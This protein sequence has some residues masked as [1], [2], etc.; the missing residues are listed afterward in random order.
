M[1]HDE[2]NEHAGFDRTYEQIIN[3][4]Y[5]RELSK[6][7]TDYLKH[8]SKCQV[9]RIR[10]HKSY[11][12]LQSILS[13]FIFF[14]T[15]TIDFVLILSTFHTDMNNVMTITNKFK[16]RVIIVP[17]KNIWIAIIWVKALFDRFNLT[18]W[19]FFKIIISNKNRKFLSDL[20][21]TLF[22][23]LNVKLLYSTVYHSQIDDASKR[24]N[25]IIEI[26]L[27]YHIQIFNDCKDW[28]T[29]VEIMQRTINNDIFSTN[30]SFNEICYEF[31]S[32]NSSNLLKTCNATMKSSSSTKLE[33]I[34]SIAMT[35]ISSKKLYDQ[36]HQSL[37]LKIEDWVLLRFYKDYQILSSIT[38][39]LKLFQQYVNSFEILEKIGNL[40]YRLKISEHWKIWF[41]ISIA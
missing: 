35:Q 6:Q 22:S 23:Q 18:N 27:R 7:L 1:I 2:F 40:A 10:K 34:D 19:D 24:T 29:I 21:S 32:I 17:D 13:S 16:K 41:V 12:S 28:S 20:W 15:L 8:C 25:Q 31:T 33:I 37:I 3:S 9:N 38:L 26:A 36:K 11:D 39:S 14:Y 5:I 4:W 30:K